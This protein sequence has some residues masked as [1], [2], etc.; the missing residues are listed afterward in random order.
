MA[1]QTRAYDDDH[2]PVSVTLPGRGTTTYA[3]KTDGRLTGAGEAVFGYADAT[4]RITL[5]HA[6]RRGRTRSPTTARSRPPP[7][8][9]RYGYTADMELDS[10][11]LAGAGKL[12]ADPRRRRAC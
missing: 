1:A 3:R 4:T 10:I 6:R 7:A 9:T 12:D 2:Y 8:S 5:G 11:Q